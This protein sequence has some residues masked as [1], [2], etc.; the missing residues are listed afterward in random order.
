MGNFLS[1]KCVQVKSLICVC[2]CAFY[3]KML[4]TYLENPKSVVVNQ[5]VK[6]TNVS[7][8][9]GRDGS[10]KLHIKNTLQIL[11]TKV[12]SLSCFLLMRLCTMFVC[13]LTEGMHI[14]IGN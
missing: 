10:N 5:K 14:N 7:I 6:F 3:M 9:I 4:L 13:S 1:H 11:K 12:H 8:Y 2:V